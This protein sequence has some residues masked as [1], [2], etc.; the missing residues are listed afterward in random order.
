MSDNSLFSDTL[1]LR[2]R[3]TVSH[4]APLPSAAQLT[5]LLSGSH[6]PAAL[7]LSPAN[8]SFQSPPSHAVQTLKDRLQAPFCRHTR[9]MSPSLTR[10]P[11]VRPH[12]TGQLLKICHFVKFGCTISPT[13]LGMFVVRDELMNHELLLQLLPPSSWPEDASP[14][15]V[16]TQ[17]LVAL[18]EPA[19]LCGSCLGAVSGTWAPPHPGL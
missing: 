8:S 16:G 12:S 17:S 9:S 15:V 5:E 2:Q 13:S 1:S 4:E 7:A 19:S 6:I 18:T 10:I 3:K 14:P 11:H